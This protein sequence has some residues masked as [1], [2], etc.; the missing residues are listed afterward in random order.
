MRSETIALLPKGRT[1]K[2]GNPLT[3]QG[4]GEP[5][6]GCKIWPRASEEKDGGE[7]NIDGQNVKCPDNATARKIKPDDHVDIRGEVHAIDEPPA[8]YIGKAVM[9][10]TKRVTT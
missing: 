4:P 1:D 8:R 9:L 2:N 6:F 3:L 10:K 7:I 5:I